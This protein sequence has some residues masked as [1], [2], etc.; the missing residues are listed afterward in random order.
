MT[1]GQIIHL[2]GKLL[3]QWTSGHHNEVM[4]ELATIGTTR[5]AHLM[6]TVAVGLASTLGDYDRARFFSRLLE[7][8]EA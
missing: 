7:G 1:Q 6:M 3:A 2:T 5:S 4:R 8:Y